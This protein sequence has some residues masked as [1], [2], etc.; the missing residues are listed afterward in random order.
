MALAR[1]AR[2]HLRGRADDGARRHGPGRDPPAAAPRRRGPRTRRSCIVSHD[3]GVVAGLA[4]RDRGDGP[5]RRSSRARPPRRVLATR[6]ARGPARSSARGRRSRSGVGSGRMT[7][8]PRS[9]ATDVVGRVRSAAAGRR[10]RSTT[11]RSRSR[12]ARSSAIVGESGSGQ[13]D[14]RPR[15]P[16]PRRAR[17]AATCRSSG[18]PVPRDPRRYPAD[19]AGED[20]ARVPGPGRGARPDAHGRR[21]ARGAAAPPHDARR[22]RR[23]RSAPASCST[24]VGLARGAPRA[25]TRTSCPEA[26]SSACRSRARSRRTPRSWSSTSRC[27]RSTSARRARCCG[28]SRDLRGAARAHLRV[29]HPRPV[30]RPAVRDAG[31]RARAAAGSSSRARS[32]RSSRARGTSTRATLLDSVLSL[33]PAIARAQLGG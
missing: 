21:R 16:R 18:M 7:R 14:A 9:G 33:D 11:S 10:A 31:A 30:G 25:A 28:C 24:Q 2:A 15:A 8:R 13:D 12:A 26:R 22:R 20:P 1:R 3:L 5:R 4:D 29:R 19:A 6:R 32:A 17:R 27:R 23:A